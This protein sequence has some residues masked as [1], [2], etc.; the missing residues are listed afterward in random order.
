MAFQV[1]APRVA[2]AVSLGAASIA[3]T[4]HA[5]D[6]LTFGKTAQRNGYNPNE[7]VLNAQTVPGLHPL[8]S[9]TLTAMVFAQPT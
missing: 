6:W 5:D 8:W 1:L 7:T 3:S 4:A 9:A 2:F